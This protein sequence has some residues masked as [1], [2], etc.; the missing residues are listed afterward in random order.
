MSNLFRARKAGAYV[1]IVALLLEAVTLVNYL[2]WTVGVR[3]VDPIIAGGF[4]LGLAAGI[5]ALLLSSDLL[6]VLNTA[7]CSCGVLQ[8]IVSNAGSFADAYQGIVMFGDSSQVGR[9]LT[10]CASAFLCVLLL[11]VSGFLG[12]GKRDA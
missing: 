6:T 12:F 10:I 3:S 5:C 4:A 11:I 8:L 9:I 7:L 2:A 1:L